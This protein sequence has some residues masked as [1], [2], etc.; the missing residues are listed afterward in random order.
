MITDQH[1]RLDVSP[2]GNFVLQAGKNY[3]LRP[4][5]SLRRIRFC[6]QLPDLCLVY[7]VLQ[8][9][10]SFSDFQGAANKQEKWSAVP[11]KGRLSQ[12]VSVCQ[13]CTILCDSLKM[14]HYDK[15]QK[16]R[17]YMGTRCPLYC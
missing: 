11:C 8:N 4:V 15:R 13:R 6:F 2:S 9:A 12:C 7:F 3:G 14:M 1:C 5:V 17:Q 10:Q 16:D